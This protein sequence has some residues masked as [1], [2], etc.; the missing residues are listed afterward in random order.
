[1]PDFPPAALVIAHPGHE[2]KVHRWLELA[3]PLVF[4]LTDGSGHGGRSRLASTA[5][6][7]ARTG[8]R[9]GPIFGRMADRDLYRSLLAGRMEPFIGLSEELAESLRREGIKLVAGDAVE[10]FNP[11]HDVC[12]LLLNAAVARLRAGG[13]AAENCDFLLD[14]GP[15]HR[16]A[17]DHEGGVHLELDGP[18][19]ARKLAA[20]RSYPGLEEEVARA[21]ARHGSDA[22]RNERLRQVRYGLD[23][24]GQFSRPPFYEIHG[25]RQVAAGFYREVLRYHAHVAPLAESLR[26]LSVPASEP[27]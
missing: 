26:S 25:E 5:A 27:A 7:L 2:L 22:F 17:E 8:A 20:A 1:M 3:R 15:D 12:R 13:Q 14:G 21:L 16:P 24:G 10:G 4:V 18:A 23:I 6:L 11:G 19:L 9:P